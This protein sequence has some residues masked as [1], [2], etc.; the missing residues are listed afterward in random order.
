[1]SENNEKAI[2][3]SYFCNSEVNDLV[4]FYSAKM[5][6]SES[7]FINLCINTYHSQQMALKSFSQLDD[8]VLRLE[9]LESKCTK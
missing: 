6:V 2:R 5:G 4:K 1:M 9:Q 8:I 7:A 3:K